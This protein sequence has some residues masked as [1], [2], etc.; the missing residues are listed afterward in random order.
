MSSACMCVAPKPVHTRPDDFVYAPLSG[1][2]KRKKLTD[3]QA[4]KSDGRSTAAAEI[5]I[6][7]VARVCLT[8]LAAI[9]DTVDD[10]FLCYLRAFDIL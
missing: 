4:N 10:A 8:P 9:L 5:I 2:K 1:P 6:G 7:G 3:R